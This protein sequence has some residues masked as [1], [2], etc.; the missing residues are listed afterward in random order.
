VEGVLEGKQKQADIVA[1]VP[2]GGI[3]N[4]KLTLN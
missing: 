1:S 2:A 4:V 3:S